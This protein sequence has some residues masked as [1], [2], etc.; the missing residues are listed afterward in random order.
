MINEAFVIPIADASLPSG[1]AAGRLHASE[2]SETSESWV[3]E[4]EGGTK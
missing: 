2:H 1:G 4:T 3:N